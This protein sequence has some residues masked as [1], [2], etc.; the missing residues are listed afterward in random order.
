MTMTTV[1]KNAG[2]S[3]INQYLFA[4]N[5]IIEGPNT[6]FLRRP[7]LASVETYRWLEAALC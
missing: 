6:T 1:L 7:R 5:K 4:P 3:Y 2:P